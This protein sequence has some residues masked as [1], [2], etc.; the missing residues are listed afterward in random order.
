M[1]N[2]LTH[3]P[4]CLLLGFAAAAASQAADGKNRDGKDKLPDAPRVNAEL[5]S[6]IAQAA[7]AARMAANAPQ[8]EPATQGSPASPRLTLHEAEQ[9]AIQHN[10]R[11]SVSKLMALAQHQV[12]RETRSAELPTGTA[13]LTAVQ[14]QDASRIS[15]GAL[16]ASRLFEHAGAGGGFTQLIT[17]FGRTGNLVA[18]AK[19]QEKAQDA[20]ALATTEDIVLATD[21]AFY[22]ALEAQALLRV[23][24]QNT[25]NRQTTDNQVSAYTKSK[26]KST[27]DLSF[28]DV[29]LSQARLLELD[30][31]DNA[32]SSMAALDA[33]LGLDHLVNYE[34]AGDE[35]PLSAPP[36]DAAELVQTALE[37]RPDLRALNYEQQAAVRFSHAERGQMLPSIS[38]SGT[39]GSVPI[40][41]AQY[42]E[43]N[44]WGGIGVNMKIPVFNG[45][46][47]SAQAKEASI[48]AEA[49]A[50]QARDLRDRIVRDVRTA[51][52]AAN[53]AYQ[54][55]SVSE[56]L[57][58]QANLALGL[59]QTRYDL[60]LSSIVEL[61][62]AQYQQT[63][64]AMGNTNAQYQY[65]LSL[66][67]LN[68]QI[69]AIQ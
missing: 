28:A 25:Q 7:P 50:E 20:N 51:W 53:T 1:R 44:W 37:Q 35:G 6:E 24:Q 23:A 69:G 59:A 46:L 65:R 33:V 26:L 8:T 43:N 49:A 32:D 54:R 2:R 52:L 58:A 34:L 5:L 61:S 55:V 62:Q 17:D 11:I 21:Q 67:T 30:A 60:G 3:W 13:A 64:A 45:F 66:A 4:L 22:T 31:K 48:R 38:A 16:T 18:W 47:Y 12:V 15:A 57:L 41:P 40:R 9:M 29:N 10:P 42:Y 63:D 36:A 56:A 19:L 14:A 39:V 27:L 68:Y